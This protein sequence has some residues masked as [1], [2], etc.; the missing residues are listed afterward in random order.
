[1]VGFAG[2][3]WWD[4]SLNCGMAVPLGHCSYPSSCSSVHR[5]SSVQPFPVFGYILNTNV[6]HIPM[7]GILNTNVRHVV[8]VSIVYIWNYTGSSVQERSTHPPIWIYP[9]QQSVAYTNVWHPKY[10]CVA[11][12]VQVWIYLGIYCVYL[13]L[14]RHLSLAFI[15]IA[16]T[17]TLTHTLS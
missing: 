1:M 12:R 8:Q 17:H 7:C 2:G 16:P 11:C 10:Q 9:K 5:P 14:Y 4:T 13:E 15:L 6:W 3:Q